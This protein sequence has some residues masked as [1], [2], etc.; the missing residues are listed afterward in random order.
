MIE[1]LAYIQQLIECT[2]LQHFNELINQIY[3]TMDKYVII[4]DLIR[5][6]HSF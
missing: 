4:V 2:N 5:I 1:S 3:K 6:N